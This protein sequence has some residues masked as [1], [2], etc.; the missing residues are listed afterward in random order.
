MDDKLRKLLSMLSGGSMSSNNDDR[1]FEPLAPMSKEE[2]TEWARI[3]NK[4]A[5]AQSIA[6]EAEAE[7]MIFWTRIEKKT[8]IYDKNLRIDN[9][10]ILIEVEKKNNCLSH[11][12]ARPGFCDGNCDECSLNPDKEIGE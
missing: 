6:K 11:G 5:Q 9:G 4:V 12:E 2:A 1:Q 8:G 7:R 3:N 10:M